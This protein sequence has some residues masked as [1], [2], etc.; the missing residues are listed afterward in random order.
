MSPLY[1][2]WNCGECGAEEVD[3]TS[4]EGANFRVE[5][6]RRVFR[7]FQAFR[8]SPPGGRRP[9][10]GRPGRPRR[11][12]ASTAAMLVLVAALATT[13]Y[14][15]VSE[16]EGSGLLAFTRATGLGGTGSAPADY[17]VPVAQDGV[18]HRS[19]EW[20]YKGRTYTWQMDITEASYEHFRSLERP[21]RRYQEG[22]VWH[23]RPAYDIYVSHPD[24]DP[25]IN[26]LGKALRDQAQGQG[27]SD[28]ESLSFALSFVQSLP[29]TRDD[30]T[31]GFD[32]YPRFPVET[33]VDYG[34]DCE[35]TSILYASLVVAMGY[36]AVMLSPP[37]HMAVGVAA[38]AS[39]AGTSYMHQEQRF[40]YAE[41]TGHGYH[42]GKVP[43]QYQGQ[44][45]VVYD[46]HPK[47]LFSLDVEFGPVTRD[48]HQEIRMKATHT[49]SAAATGV[50]LR[51]TVGR[52]GTDPYDE[53]ACEAGDLAPGSIV[54]CRVLID[55]N[56]VPRGT[57][58]S[59]RA[60]VQDSRF[61][62]DETA[63]LPWVPRA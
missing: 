23:V 26:A 1:G 3:F 58:V 12:S 45:V 5:P 32:E 24:D 31:T 60:F 28:D 18:Y 19:F 53:G 43:E 38:S 41:T 47:P 16:P 36:G 11:R 22:G 59:V 21:E 42:I 39:V 2:T 50:Q 48:G 8:R 51:T 7:P 10:H 13:A 61:I 55:L 57:R 15:L 20:Q 14:L 62:Y 35:D 17:V 30:V 44:S 9:F 25:F 37:G 6:T 63:S 29:Y 27:F 49:G 52:S 54:E 46:L 4:A 56:K 34:G 33:L 40:L